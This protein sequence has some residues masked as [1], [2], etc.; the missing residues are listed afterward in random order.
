M[1][2]FYQR[3][4]ILFI[5]VALITT[6]CLYLG[7]Y[8]SQIKL[9]FFP[10]DSKTVPWLAAQ[11]PGKPT[12]GTYIQVEE[13]T[14]NIAYRFSVSPGENYPYAAY[15]LNFLDASPTREFV[16]LS[17]FRGVSFRVQCE[18]KVLLEFSLHSYD[19]AVTVVENA[20][21]HRVA[22][23]F[24]T[25]EQYE[26]EVQIYF[27][28]LET[29]YWWLQLFE[30]ELTDRDYDHSKVAAFRFG[31]SVETPEDTPIHVK[32]SSI[33]LFGTSLLVNYTSYLCAAL[34][35]LAY[36][37]WLF[38]QYVTATVARVKEKVRLDLPLVAYQK[39]SVAP[40]SD[41]KKDE[42]LR[43]MATEYSNPDLNIEHIISSL[44]YNR[45]KVNDIIRA[46]LG[47][48][49]SSYLNKLRLTEAARLL[50][51]QGAISIAEVAYAVGY[52]NVSYFST[53]FKAEYG[54]SPKV[55]KEGVAS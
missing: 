50:S 52:N 39:L 5:T 19:A 32:I 18:S 6:C 49:F 38:R 34:I 15:V 23:S 44:G 40:H 37:F 16:D 43:F 4:V 48:T 7:A 33:E 12:D 9:V 24:F 42:V 25:C 3:A 35:W 26:T 8:A 53:L 47:L 20:L 30:L 10:G 21:T 45:H 1:L 31:N 11:V 41:K 54:C 22:S 36:M 55:F 51:E 46:E 2:Q 28:A 14:Q 27:D 17:R 13:G 29:A